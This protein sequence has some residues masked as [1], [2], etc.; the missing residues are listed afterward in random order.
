[1]K[2]FGFGCMRLPMTAQ[3][4][5]DNAVLSSMVD[6]FI[7]EGFTYFDTAHGYHSGRSET[8]LRECL[9]SRYPRE[10]YLLADKLTEDYFSKREDIV[11]FFEN[12]LVWCGVDYFDYYLLHSITE[13]NYGKFLSADAFTE[14]VRLRDEGKIRHLGISYHDGPELLE[15]I[16]NDHP[17]IEFVQ[18][19]FNYADYDDPTIQ[20]RAVYDVCLR[21]GKGIIVM[22]PCKGGGLVNLPDGAQEVFRAL[23]GGSAASY[24]IRFAASQ[25]GVFMVLSGMSNFDQL[26]DNLSFMKDFH[27][28][29]DAERE[30]VDKVRAIISGE[31]GVPCTACRYCVAGCPKNIPIPDLFACYNAK[32]RYNDWNSDFY[33]SV[34]TGNGRGKASDCIACGKCEHTCPQHLPVRELLGKVSS[35]LEN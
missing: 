5:V 14:T 11:P 2:N 7:A 27:P 15:R 33:Y 29:T 22:E 4:T 10:A 21:H 9:T 32:L 3:D 26:R 23:G 31:A 30:A 24:A 17:E 28:L 6:T 18:I 20:S 16:L 35:A 12:Q 19:Q 1:M 8:A 34:C 13:H 25:Q